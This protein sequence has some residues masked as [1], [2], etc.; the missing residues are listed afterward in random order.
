ME[1]NTGE[2]LKAVTIF[3]YEQ[4]NTQDSTDASSNIELQRNTAA[5]IA[6]IAIILAFVLFIMYKK[7]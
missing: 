6:I 3:D 7:K 4:E 5:V 2:L 1:Y